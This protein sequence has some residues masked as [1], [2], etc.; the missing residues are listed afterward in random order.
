M[1][2]DIKQ[3]S[4]ENNQKGSGKIV[5]LMKK[6]FPFFN[7]DDANDYSQMFTTEQSNEGTS[8]IQAESTE[9]EYNAALG[10]AGAADRDRIFTKR[11]PKARL[12]K[13]SIFQEMAEDS[14]IGG[15][16]DLLLSYAL[17]VDRKTNLSVFL[18]AKKPE[19]QAVVDRLNKEL[20]ATINKNLNSWAW[21]T[22]VYGIN[23]IRPYTEQGK[24][25]VA[26]EANYYTHPSRIKM[27]ERSGNLA[28]FTSQNFRRKENN[29]SVELASPW[30][31]VPLKIPQWHPEP[32]NEPVSLS[33]DEYSLFDDA[34]HRAPNESQDYGTSLLAGAF[35]S[36]C[37]FHQSVRSLMASR[38]NASRI[39][40][41][42]SVSTGDLNVQ[43]SAMYLN[44]IANQLKS[45]REAQSRQAEKTGILPT[46][47]TSLIPVMAG[48]AK[49]GVT[50]DTQ[51][52]DPN[53]SA[54][55]DVM[56]WVK[57]M[58]GGGMGIDPALL[59]FAE[60]I[61]SGWGGEGS[62][63]RTSIQSALRA[64]LIRGAVVD[65]VYRCVDIHTAFRDGKVWTA[66]TGYPFEIAFNSLNTAIE[67]EENA[68]A[69][70]KAN[71]VNVLAS[72]LEVVEAGLIGKSDSLKGYVYK[73]LLNLDD[74]LADKIISEL[75]AAAKEAEAAGADG[76]FMESLG[77]R[78]INDQIKEMLFE[79]M[80]K[81]R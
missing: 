2:D 36:W 29:G 46:I 3:A 26:F 50:I 19:D 45:D 8:Y 79:E 6:V 52:I 31:L 65:F 81:I 48:G 12:D 17:S 56:L 76:G 44:S 16:I 18:V 5:G 30:T 38:N 28:G 57:I 64:N 32:N 54:I 35:E 68:A 53:I 25:I 47:F 80:A 55:E 43:Q 15:A 72:A 42:I 40:R 10:I 4:S 62:W 37:N 51:M 23:F 66:E 59:G 71:Y 34:Y 11:L 41:L 24:G 61:S 69:E 1:S 27:Y 63:F 21:V 22:A 67:E 20:M 58:L 60:Q 7:P 74:A 78:D 73:D 49:G 77:D 9:N 13:Y 33:G 14:L 75:A 39:D 70:S